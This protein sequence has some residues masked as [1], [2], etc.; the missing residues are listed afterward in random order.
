M[1]HRSRIITPFSVLIWLVVALPVDAAA[2]SFTIDTTPLG[3]GSNSNGIGPLGNVGS[4]AYYINL[5]QTFTAPAS[6]ATVNDFTLWID[7]CQDAPCSPAL[8]FVAVLQEW[9]RGTPGNVL[10][11][12]S[13][14]TATNNHGVGGFEEFIFLT[15][16]ISLQPGVQYVAYFT[17]IAGNGRMPLGGT[18]Y[19]TPIPGGGDTLGRW[20]AQ[21]PLDPYWL[22]VITL[23][24]NDLAFRL[25]TVPEPA[26]LLLSG[27]G[28]LALVVSRVGRVR[29]S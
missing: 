24:S 25:N 26:T 28:L 9:N 21:R 12:S 10:F 6:G 20:V 17:V 22:E 1:R 18:P 29:R 15:G 2:S 23:P 14:R 16:G 11:Q 4:P 8:A 13:P 7:D 5:G 19:G 3:D 27:L